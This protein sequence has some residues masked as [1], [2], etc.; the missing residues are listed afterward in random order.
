[1]FGHLRGDIVRMR[2]ITTLLISFC[3]IG[4]CGCQKRST[5]E[6]FGKT[7]YLDGAGNWGFGAS[8]VPGGLEQAGYHG[9]VELYVWTLSFNPLVDQL[10]IPGARLRASA[11]ARRIEDYHERYPDRKINVIALSAGTGVATWAIRSIAPEICK[12]GRRYRFLVDSTT[13]TLH[14]NGEV[15]VPRCGSGGTDEIGR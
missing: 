14:R 11:L 1:M 10:N 3:L 6:N 8:E 15:G 7:Y 2:I 12:E 9:D 4:T 13:L 5:A